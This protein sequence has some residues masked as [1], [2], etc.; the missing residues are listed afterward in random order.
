L[1]CCLLC[2]KKPRS[3]LTLQIGMV[4]TPILV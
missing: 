2:S 3:K 4:E 1:L